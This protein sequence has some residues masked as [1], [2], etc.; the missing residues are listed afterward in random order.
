MQEVGLARPY[1]ND[2]GVSAGAVNVGDVGSSFVNGQFACD[3]GAGKPALLLNDV[4]NTVP[5]L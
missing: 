1:V 2:R 3:S 4:P 5:S